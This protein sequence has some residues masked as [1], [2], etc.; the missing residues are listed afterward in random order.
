MR[1]RIED[2]DIVSAQEPA[3]HRLVGV[4]GEA[5]PGIGVRAGGATWPP[6]ADVMKNIR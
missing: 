1:L 6:Q 2:S 3:C 4:A 5:I